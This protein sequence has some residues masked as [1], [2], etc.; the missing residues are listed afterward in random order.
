MRSEYR[1]KKTLGIATRKF[2]YMKTVLRQFQNKRAKETKW[3]DHHHRQ[4]NYMC[5]RA[6]HH[7]ITKMIQKLSLLVCGSLGI[8][9]IYSCGRRR[10]VSYAL[11]NNLRLNIVYPEN[12]CHILRASERDRRRHR[13]TWC[14][15]AR[16]V[17]RNLC[18]ILST[19]SL[20]WTSFD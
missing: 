6:S 14:T 13:R 4:N 1:S 5:Q 2:A 3:T 8:L 18:A 12:S 16:V 10:G 11:R 7:F 20:C 17:P 15:P 9:Y 19:F